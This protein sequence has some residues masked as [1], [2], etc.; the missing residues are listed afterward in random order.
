MKSTILLVLALLMTACATTDQGPSEKD[1]EVRKYI[2]EAGLEEIHSIREFDNPGHLMVTRRYIIAY[3]RKT[4]YLFEYA[5]DCKLAELGNDMRPSDSRRRA[6]AI[7][8]G[9]DTFRG[10]PV[11]TMYQIT[12]PQ[13]EALMQIARS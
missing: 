7:S 1:L 2:D 10:C 4:Q 8:V 5:H 3:M 6:R 11:K 9:T 12:Y 13:A